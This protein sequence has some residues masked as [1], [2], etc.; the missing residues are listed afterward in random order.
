MVN[1]MRARSLAAALTVLCARKI[2]N[3]AG[4]MDAWIPMLKSRT[5]AK[6]QSLRGPLGRA[7]ITAANW[8]MASSA[9]LQ[10]LEISRCASKPR[11]PG[12]N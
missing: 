1:A 11:L 2:S 12:P 4:F 10:I 7:T 8:T 3:G 5:L 6:S 9:L